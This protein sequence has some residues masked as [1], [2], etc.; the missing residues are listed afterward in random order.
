MP[1][2]HPIGDKLGSSKADRDHGQLGVDVRDIGG[3]RGAT[4]AD[5]PE[6]VN[7]SAELTAT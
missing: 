6:G 1:G 4:V 2:E 7:G 3:F 5:R